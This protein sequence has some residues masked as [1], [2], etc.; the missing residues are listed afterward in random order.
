MGTRYG[1]GASDD[2]DDQIAALEAAGRRRL[3]H[4]PERLVADDEPLAPR[5][6]PAVGAANDLEISPAHTHG[7]A[8]DEEVAGA[9]SHVAD[10]VHAHRPWLHRNYGNR[11]HE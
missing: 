3:E 10:L 9:W 8:F 2:A 6:R 11:A 7:Q 4:A 5:W 1:I